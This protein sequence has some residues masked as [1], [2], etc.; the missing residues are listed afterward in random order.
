MN[1]L[2]YIYALPIIIVIMFSACGDDDSKGIIRY[3]ESNIESYTI[4]VGS[5]TGGQELHPDSIKERIN[6][7]FPTTIFENYTNT[8]MNFIDD[9]IFIEQSG[10]PAEMSR[11]TFEDG[12]IYLYNDETPVYYG[13]GDK[14]NLHIRQHYIAYK[15]PNDKKFTNRQLTPK[16]NINTNNV[17]QESPFLTIEDMKSEADTLI[18]CTRSSFFR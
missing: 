16:K 9:F 18:W 3:I 4:Y 12:S 2:K 6:E 8:S 11:Y 7:I 1:S 14:T 13:D 5:A 17:A 10:S 15:Q